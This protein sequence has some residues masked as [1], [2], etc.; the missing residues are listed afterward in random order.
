MLFDVLELHAFEHTVNLNLVELCLEELGDAFVHL[1]LE[2]LAGRNKLITLV[3]VKQ[4]IKPSEDKHVHWLW[5]VA[6]WQGFGGMQH[7]LK[8]MP[9]RTRRGH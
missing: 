4:H 1:G 7:L 8:L 2:F 5:H 9:V 3:L 6:G